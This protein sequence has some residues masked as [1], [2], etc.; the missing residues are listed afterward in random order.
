[1]VLGER[2]GELERRLSWERG[3]GPG[4]EGGG[5]GRERGWSWERGGEQQ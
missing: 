4:R 3:G 2:G 5:P 1:M